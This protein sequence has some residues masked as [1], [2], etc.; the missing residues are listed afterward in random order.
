MFFLPESG[1]DDVS[2][3]QHQFYCLWFYP[4]GEKYWHSCHKLCIHVY[5]YCIHV[6]YWLLLIN[7]YIYCIQVTI[8]I[9]YTGKQEVWLN[10]IK[11][12]TSSAIMSIYIFTFCTD[13]AHFV[14][15]FMFI[16]LYICIV[17]GF[18]P[19]VA[20]NRTWTYFTSCRWEQNYFSSIVAGNRMI[21]SI[22]C[23]IYRSL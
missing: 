7:T 16:D 20:V 5:P 15:V 3:K 10:K 14:N 17:I 9:L 1:D 21:L 12:V 2:E 23:N 8:P 4:T 11:V 18:L 22:K 6:Y 19:T 13:F